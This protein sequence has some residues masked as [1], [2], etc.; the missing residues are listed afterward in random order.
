MPTTIRVGLAGLATTGLLLTAPTA[1]QAGVPAN[2]TAQSSTTTGTTT[3]TAAAATPRL[4][5]QQ[6]AHLRKER[7]QARRER[8]E[9]RR[10][11][12]ER[13]ERRQEHRRVV[14]RRHKIANAYHIA[15]R[16]IGDPYVWGATG[17]GSF[18]CSGLTSYAYHHAGMSLPRTAA[19]QAG[20]VR[21]IP[22][23]K[24]RRGDFMFF[25][26]GGH[27]YHVGLFVGWKHGKRVIL[28]A[29]HTGASVRKEA[30]WTDGWFAGTLRLR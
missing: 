20:S 2:P 6:R 4:T 22:R 24:M 11:A 1:A 7:R 21:H 9:H 5:A 12:R 13:R 23:I 19:E 28:N 29:P 30:V 14:H 16:Q 17:P 26:E 10:E 18:D 15:S 27:V 25:S 3:A 8:R